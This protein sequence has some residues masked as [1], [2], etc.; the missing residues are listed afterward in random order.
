MSLGRVVQEGLEILLFLIVS[1]LKLWQTNAA[2]TKHTKAKDL[3]ES[4]K[5]NCELLFGSKFRF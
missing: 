1:S 3:S 4:G 5:Q 2:K